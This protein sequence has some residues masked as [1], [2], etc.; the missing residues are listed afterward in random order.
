MIFGVHSEN[1]GNIR[2]IEQFFSLYPKVIAGRLLR[3]R[4]V[5]YQDLDEFENVLLTVFLADVSKRIVVHTFRKVDRVEH[6]DLVRLINRDISAFF[7]FE[8][9][10]LIVPAVH[11]FSVNSFRA[12]P[13]E[14]SSAFD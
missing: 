5:F 6:L 1:K 3:R 9:V 14:H 12:A 4:C 11:N 13:L 8:I 7:V 2:S 10:S